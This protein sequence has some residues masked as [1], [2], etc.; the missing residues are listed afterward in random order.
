M[1]EPKLELKWIKALRPVRRRLGPP[2][3]M[4]DFQ[5]AW[6]WNLLWESL[7]QEPQG[8]LGLS[9]HL[10]R[11]AEAQNEHFWNCHKA[12]V[13][14]VF[15]I[16]Q[17]GGHEMI[18]YRPLLQVIEEQQKIMKSH[19]K[20]EGGGGNQTTISTVSTAIHKVAEDSLPSPS[21]SGFAFDL[22]DP[23]QIQ[24]QTTTH[25]RA[26]AR[27]SGYTQ[28]D[29]DARDLRKMAKA[30]DWLCVTNGE[31]VPRGHGLSPR[32]MF[33]QVCNRAGVTIERGLDLDERCKKWPEKV[34]EWLREAESKKPPEKPQ[35]A[36][37]EEVWSLRTRAAPNRA[38]QRTQDN[39]AANAREKFGRTG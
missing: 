28:A 14:A 2:P 32:Q 13:L 21:Q 3:G 8:Y 35:P 31:G 33:E 4:K 16:A 22:L 7:E 12:V 6:F 37:S 27:D 23:I 11:I 18:F 25:A 5:Q 20:L 10:W 17:V 19:R 15:D 38:E 1:P 24:K 34:P 29:F 36:P 9:G 26:P 30:W 39:L